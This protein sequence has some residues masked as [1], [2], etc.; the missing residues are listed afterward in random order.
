[1]NIVEHYKYGGWENC[2]YISN[3]TVEVIV[4][5]NVG[6]R[7]IRLGFINGPNILYEVTADRGKIGGKDNRLYGGD[8][9]IA[10]ARSKTQN[11]LS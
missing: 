11:I 1:M 4:T 6:P 2:L 10:F 9:V 7:V 8:K 3:G 5:T